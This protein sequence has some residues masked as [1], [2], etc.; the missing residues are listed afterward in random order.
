MPNDS[1]TG[2]VL[3]P[4][5]SG[6]LYNQGGYDQG[7]YGAPPAAFYDAD[8]DL[9]LQQ[10]I[11]GITGLDGALVR[12]RWQPNVP[13]QPDPTTNWCA[14]GV[15]D[16]TPDDTPAIVHSASAPGFDTIYRH[17]EIEVLASFY[18]PTAQVYSSQARDGMYLPQNNDVLKQYNASLIESKRIRYVPE[19]VNQQWVKRCD[20][21]FSLRRQVIRSYAILNLASAEINITT[22][23]V[24]P[25]V[26]T[27][28]VTGPV[29]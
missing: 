13:K 2:G 8:L 12:P 4:L 28:S 5:P 11:V 24:P 20:L 29:E 27:A 10:M 16:I 18:G 1:S 15:V 9:I 21:S 7:G 14:I 17:E 3:A 23:D 19:L 26:R 22:D 6:E 25:V